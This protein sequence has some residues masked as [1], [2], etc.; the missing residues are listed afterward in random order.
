MI[1]RRAKGAGIHFVGRSSRR[2]RQSRSYPGY[3]P[4]F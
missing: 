2:Q 3:P 4:R 1:Q